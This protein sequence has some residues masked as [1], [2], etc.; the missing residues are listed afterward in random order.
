MFIQG[1]EDA[2]IQELALRGVLEISNLQAERVPKG[3]SKSAF[4]KIFEDNTPG[5]RELIEELQDNPNSEVAV[6]ALKVTETLFQSDDDEFEIIRKKLNNIRE[7]IDA[8]KRDMW[9]LDEE[10]MMNGTLY[11]M[12]GK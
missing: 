3:F 12:P 5:I 7:E 11:K 6:L 8:L 2:K 1:E 10:N 4:R 9:S